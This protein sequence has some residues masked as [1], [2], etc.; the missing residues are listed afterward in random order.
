MEEHEII[1]A[2]GKEVSGVDDKNRPFFVLK[3]DGEVIKTFK[4]T[5]KYQN[6]SD[7]I[8]SRYFEI[9]DYIDAGLRRVSWIDTVE[10]YEIDTNRTRFKVIGKLT[11]RDQLRLI[12]FIESIE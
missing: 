10:V 1:I 11:Y 7:F 6:K 8:K 5:T 4:I 2:S 9:I 12:E 3:L